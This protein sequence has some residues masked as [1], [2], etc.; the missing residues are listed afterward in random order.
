MG[1]QI[2]FYQ[3]DSDILVFR[4]YLEKQNLKLFH[5]DKNTE[6]VDDISIWGDERVFFIGDPQM[7]CRGT[8]IEYVV[9]TRS[10]NRQVPECKIGIAGGRFYLFNELYHDVEVTKTYNLLKEYVKKNYVFSK[11]ASCYFSVDFIEMYKTLKYHLVS[12]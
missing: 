11:N 12:D 9:P 7:K 4:D 3:T 8:L 1:K 5:Y 2:C 6:V 10:H